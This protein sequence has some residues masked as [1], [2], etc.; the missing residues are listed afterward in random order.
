[1]SSTT[2]CPTSFSEISTLSRYCRLEDQV[3]GVLRQ[4][5]IVALRVAIGTIFLWFGILKIAGESPVLAMIQTAYP[6]MPEPFFMHLLGVWETA[7]GIGL[8]SGVALRLTLGLFLVQ[9][10]GTLTALVMAPK[11]PT[12]FA[13]PRAQMLSLKRRGRPVPARPRNVENNTAC[14]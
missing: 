3:R 13:S 4:Y 6:F 10:S 11:P 2:S 7:I 5:G 8:I 12:K 1:M 9:M 14:R